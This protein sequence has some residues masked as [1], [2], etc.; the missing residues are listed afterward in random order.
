MDKEVR[1]EIHEE[2]EDEFNARLAKFIRTFW[3]VIIS[4]TITGCGGWFSLYYQ[5][6]DN[7]KQLNLGDRFTADDGRF[8]Q[9][10]IDHNTAQLGNV[11]TKDDILR[12]ETQIL[13]IE[14]RLFGKTE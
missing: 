3:V 13:R 8:L 12:L 6:Q 9:F 4:L 11:A 10:Q 7:T 5:V 1:A 2:I 14:S